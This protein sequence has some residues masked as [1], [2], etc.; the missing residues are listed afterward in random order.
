LADYFIFTVID[1]SSIG[2]VIGLPGDCV[3]YSAEGSGSI[4]HGV[5]GVGIGSDGSE[6]FGNKFPLIE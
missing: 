3:E 2:M 6:N 4:L 5:P 1:E